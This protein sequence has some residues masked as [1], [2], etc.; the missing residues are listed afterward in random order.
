[1]TKK[2][3]H[4][5]QTSVDRNNTDEEN[6]KKSRKIMALENATEQNTN[7]EKIDQRTTIDE[8]NG[9]GHTEGLSKGET[10]HRTR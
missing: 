8:E 1:M 10:A 6:R 9:F 5:S 4:N 7:Q 3:Q 2:T